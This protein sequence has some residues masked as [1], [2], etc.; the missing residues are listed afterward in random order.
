MCRAG[1]HAGHT[2]AYDRDKGGAEP[3]ISR[4]L[5]RAAIPLGRTSPSASS[6]LP[7]DHAGHVFV[8]LFGLAPGGV[9]RATDVATG[10]VRSYRTLSPLPDPA[11]GPSAVCSLLHWS[12][13]HAAQALPGTLPCGAR[14]FLQRPISGGSGCLAD[15]AGYY[16]SRAAERRE[17]RP[18]T[19]GRCPRPRAARFSRACGS[20]PV[21][22]PRGRRP[23]GA[24]R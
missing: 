16:T 8:P 23:C 7:G 20:R 6:G 19:N 4:V 10:A 15:S 14:T 18:L 13:A 1:T 5:S 22:A 21:P 3:A 9:C 2:R 24:D 11:S 12:S 17:K